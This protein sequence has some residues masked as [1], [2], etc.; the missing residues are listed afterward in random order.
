MILED[1]SSEAATRQMSVVS[2]GLHIGARGI[3]EHLRTNLRDRYHRGFPIIKELIQNADDGEATQ[4]HILEIQGFKG[5]DNALL[6]GR[7]LVIANNSEFKPT[8][9]EAICELGMSHRAAERKAVGKF[10]LGLKSVF[11]LCEAFFYSYS[12]PGDEGLPLLGLVNPWEGIGGEAEKFY[13]KWGAISSDDI[14]NFAKLT[15][16]F[17]WNRCFLIL[18]PLRMEF[19]RFSAKTTFIAPELWGQRALDFLDPDQ[20][21]PAICHL[22]PM[23]KNVSLLT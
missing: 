15:Q 18:V 10:G 6:R 23:L 19:H 12:Q 11:H 2:R 9:Q 16:S 4:C 17:G 3:I 21:Y 1:P 7:A 5:S 20:I 14:A 8:D 13:Q 22:L